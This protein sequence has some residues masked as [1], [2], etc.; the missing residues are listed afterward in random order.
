MNLLETANNGGMGSLN[1]GGNK[2]NGITSTLWPY[3]ANKKELDA[4]RDKPVTAHTAH[5]KYDMKG[6][7]AEIQEGTQTSGT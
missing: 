7:Q 3:R 2:T 4:E 5:S 1:S 6:M